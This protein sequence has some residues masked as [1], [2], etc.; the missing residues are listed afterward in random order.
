MVFYP[1]MT[2][3]DTDERHFGREWVGLF[4]EFCAFLGLHGLVDCGFSFFAASRLRARNWFF[5]FLIFVS[6]EGAKARRRSFEE[7]FVIHR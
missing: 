6:R 1:Q 3:M 5:G 4:C 7:W 2:Q